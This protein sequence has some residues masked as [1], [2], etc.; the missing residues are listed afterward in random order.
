MLSQNADIVVD[1]CNTLG[2]MPLWCAR[3]SRLFWIDVFRPGRVFFWEE[4]SGH[5]DFW[6]FDDLVTGIALN[7]SGGLLIALTSDVIRFDPAT[8]AIVRVFSMTAIQ[9]KHRFN[10]G[11]CDSLGR[12]WIGSMQNLLAE[13]G[14]ENATPAP[15]GGIYRIGVDGEGRFFDQKF[16]CPNAICWSPD[17]STLYAADSMA[18]WIYSYPFDLKE[19]LLGDRSNFCH[20]DG[21]GIPDGAAVDRD[22]YIWNARWGAGVVL[23]IS[24]D[25]RIDQMIRVPATNPTACAFGGEDLQTLYVTSARCGLTKPQLNDERLAGGLFAVKVK[26]PGLKKPA[27]GKI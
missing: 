14:A 7:A 15:T 24:P 10:D 17:S 2:E 20:F 9:P 26:V 5:V 19:G 3:S 1:C 21:F 4:K 25:G 27:F 6:Q 8:E 12:L 22:G 16:A 23:R 18:G 13:E 11:A